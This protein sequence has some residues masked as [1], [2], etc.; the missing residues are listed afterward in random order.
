MKVDDCRGT[1]N[2]GLTLAYYRTLISFQEATDSDK[3]IVG[4]IEQHS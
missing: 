1:E 4:N 2:M 3:I